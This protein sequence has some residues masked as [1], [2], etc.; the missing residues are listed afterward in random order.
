ME[1][2]RRE[3]VLSVRWSEQLLPKQHEQNNFAIELFIRAKH[4]ECV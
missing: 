1:W 2:N 3:Q 4:Q